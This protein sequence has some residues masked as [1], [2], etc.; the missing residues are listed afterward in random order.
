MSVNINKF[1]FDQYPDNKATSVDEGL[2]IKASVSDVAAESGQ[3]VYPGVSMQMCY[4]IPR[5]G[6]VCSTPVIRIGKVKFSQVVS[7]PNTE[8]RLTINNNFDLQEM[9]NELGQ[10]SAPTGLGFIFLVSGFST[11][12]GATTANLG[13][14]EL[15]WYVSNDGS[16]GIGLK[17]PAFNGQV[18]PC[19]SFGFHFHLQYIYMLGNP[20]EP[21]SIFSLMNPLNTG[22]QKEGYSLCVAQPADLPSRVKQMYPDSWLI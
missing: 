14:W 2:I 7:G 21:R 8:Q 20:F 18:Y 10:P 15:N 5:L 1:D 12:S 19:S 17:I 3:A 16:K 13:Q 9:T 11:Q 22:N 6:G 4:F